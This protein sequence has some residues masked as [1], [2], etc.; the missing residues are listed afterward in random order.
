MIAAL[1]LGLYAVAVAL[2]APALLARFWPSDRAP[3]LTVL[4]LQILSC[5]FLAASVGAG[6]ALAL[7]LVE[8]LSELSPALDRCADTLP[9]GEHSSVATWVGHIGLV[10][11]GA[12][13]LRILYCLLVTF[14]RARLRRRAHLRVLRMLATRDEELGVLVLDHPAPACYCLPGDI[15]ITTGALSRLNATQLEAVLL[16]ERAHVS[17]HHHVVIALAAAIGRTVPHVRLLTYAE[18]ETRRLVELI[19]DDAAVA[20]TSAPAVAAALAVIGTGHAPDLD[21]TATPMPMLLPALTPDRGTA[22]PDGAAGEVRTGSGAA[23]REGATGATGSKG[24]AG[25]AGSKGPAGAAAR[26]GAAGSKGAAGTAA[27]A[28][29]VPS[30]NTAF[31][32]DPST[33]SI[34]S[35][36]TLRRVRRL[37]RLD[38][39]LTGRAR[40]LSLTAAVFMIALPITLIGV[41]GAS[42]ITHCPPDTEDHDAGP[43]AVTAVFLDADAP[44]GCGASVDCWPHLPAPNSRIQPLADIAH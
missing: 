18:R 38:R 16:H 11:A 43:A 9:V 17:G 5:S 31:T 30:P 24:A 23:G 42:L 12:L 1:I 4:L 2:F 34:D 20:R 25:G 40:A 28:A 7:T 19:A 33:L 36:P 13:V 39:A 10:S 41:S 37:L 32:A 44:V 21:P 15:V 29:P 26:V 35:S 6:L 3:R 8:G 22:G 27:K 14:G